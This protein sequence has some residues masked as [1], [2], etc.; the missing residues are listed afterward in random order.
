[1]VFYSDGLAKQLKT[2]KRVLAVEEDVLF[3]ASLTWNRCAT[4][5]H[6]TNQKLVKKMSK[7]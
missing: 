3:I 2:A 6:Q 4:A 1:M 5:S 7:T